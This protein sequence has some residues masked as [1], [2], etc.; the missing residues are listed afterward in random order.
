MN[1][2]KYNG[3]FYK[4]VYFFKKIL[5]VV[6]K[7]ICRKISP[8]GWNVKNVGLFFKNECYLYTTPI[9]C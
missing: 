7:A 6:S 3:F 8:A 2:H 4:K 5:S 9:K 1:F